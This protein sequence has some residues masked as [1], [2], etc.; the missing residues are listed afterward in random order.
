MMIYFYLFF[1]KF[2]RFYISGY[3][4]YGLL[5]IEV[6][7]FIVSCIFIVFCFLEKLLALNNKFIEN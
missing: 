1:T 5:E 7:H 6:N 4:F 3:I 2:Y